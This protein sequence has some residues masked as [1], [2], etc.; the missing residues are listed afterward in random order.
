MLKI[1]HL[2]LFFQFLFSL[3]SLEES[4]LPSLLDE[5]DD[6]PCDID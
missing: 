5:D 6:P 4:E 1:N 2:Y 3:F